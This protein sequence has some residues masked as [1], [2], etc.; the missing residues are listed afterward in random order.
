MIDVDKD[1]AAAKT[2]MSAAL[3]HLEETLS[4]IRAGKATPKLLD[5]IRVDSYGQMMPLSAVAA[6][7]TP[8]A[9][10]ITIRP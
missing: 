2:K 9:R 10:S 7:A 1:Y 5:G 8:D 6:I 4:H 3:D